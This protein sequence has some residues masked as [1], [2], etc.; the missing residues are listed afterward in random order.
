MA[1]RTTVAT[2]IENWVRLIIPAVNP[3]TDEMVPMVSPVLIN[4]VVYM[5]FSGRYFLARG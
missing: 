4:K 3:K 5:A 1:L 2:R